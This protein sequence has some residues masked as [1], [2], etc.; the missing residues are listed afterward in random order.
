MA[1]LIVVGDNSRVYMRPDNVLRED[2]THPAQVTNHPVSR[3]SVP[4]DHRI[5]EPFT[6]DLVLRITESPLASEGGGANPILYSD[7]SGDVAPAQNIDV[8][9][10]LST[11]LGNRPRSV[12]F[13]QSL[14]RYKAELWEYVS[15]SLGLLSPLVMTNITFT[16]VN[17]RHVDFNI[18]LQEIEFIEAQRV[19][20]PPLQVL[21]KAPET[22]PT[23]DSGDKAKKAV[24]S[25]G[26]LSKVSAADRS[27]LKNISNWLSGSDSTS[28]NIDFLKTFGF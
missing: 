8:I 25:D 24:S 20:L 19:S 9:L 16:I 10:Q 13:Y 7:A 3:T 23:V 14:L 1:S 18:S 26:D 5:D 6:V 2:I 28:G 27:A 11:Q 12:L 15:E 17:A 4:A 22:C 21:K